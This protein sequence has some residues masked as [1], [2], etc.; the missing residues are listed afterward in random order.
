MVRFSEFF[1]A[2]AKYS[3]T[4]V[5]DSNFAHIIK[6]REMRMNKFIKVAR[7]STVILFLWNS[8]YKPWYHTIISLQYILYLIWRGRFIFW[9]DFLF[10]W[11]IRKLASAFVENDYPFLDRNYN[12]FN[13]YAFMIKTFNLKEL[14]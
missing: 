5:L 14:Y 11:K 12:Y 3:A 4:I 6:E 10:V 8:C 2:T 1:G 13:F 9:E 7:Y